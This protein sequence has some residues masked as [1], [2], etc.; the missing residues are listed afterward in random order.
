MNKRVLAVSLAA[1]LAIT[2][3]ACS[4][5]GQTV[6]GQGGNAGPGTTASSGSPNV[7]GT[8]GTAASTSAPATSQSSSASPSLSLAAQLGQGLAQ[9]KTAHLTLDVS[10]AGQTITGSGDEELSSG[11]LVALDLS[12][13][14]ESNLALRL[15]IVGGKTYVR[16]PSTLNK[17]GKPYQLVSA[18]SS[19]P[20]I[21]TLASSLASTQSSASLSSVTAFVSAA[22][23]VKKIGTSG[24]N[25][26]YAIDVNPAKLPGSYAGKQALISS[27]LTSIPIRLELDSSG[28][29]VLVTENLT[30]EGQK[31]STK[32]TIGSYDKPVHIAAPPASQVSTH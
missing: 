32:I 9:A 16:L 22:R 27:G 2:L 26:T 31:V 24:S 4:S 11:K 5:G 29:P 18:K 19:D 30:V 21:R 17:S 25:T 20:T 28:R 7:S 8:S 6:D 13:T 10:A 14:V 3:A 1:P 15:I 23:S 12:E